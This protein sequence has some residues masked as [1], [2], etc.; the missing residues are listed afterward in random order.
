[1]AR[2]NEAELAVL[3][4]LIEEEPVSDARSFEYPPG[5]DRDYYR[6]AL[7]TTRFCRYEST[8]G[9]VNVADAFAEVLKFS[10]LPDS[11]EIFVLDF[12]AVIR[13]LHDRGGQN[14]SIT[15]NAG[16]F[17]EPG[18]VYEIIEARNLVAASVARIQVVGKWVSR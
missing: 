4:R 5:R 2:L 3:R 17:Y 12:S 1:M 7:V 14:E 18:I 11:I 9:F 8:N 15:I 10:S 13:F 16:N 6:P